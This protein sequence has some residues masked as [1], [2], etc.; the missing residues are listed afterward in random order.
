MRDLYNITKGT[1][2]HH[3]LRVLVMMRWWGFVEINER[4]RE[5]VSDLGKIL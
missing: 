2:F 5:R 3:R 4:E 1:D